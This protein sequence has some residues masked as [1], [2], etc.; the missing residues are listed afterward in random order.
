MAASTFERY[1][2]EITPAM[3][4]T[5]GYGNVMQVPR[6]QKVVVNIGVGEASQDSKLIDGA[7]ADL[8]AITG[9]QPAPRKAKK[10]ISNFKI[11]EGMVVGCCVTL[12]RRRMYDFMDRLINFA[13]PQVRDFRGLSTRSFDGRGNFNMGVKEQIIFPEMDYDKIDR[14]RGM[15]ITMVT[16]ADT[17]D[18]AIELLRLF[19]VPFSSQMEQVDG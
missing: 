18:E 4:E 10:A 9:Q 5:F 12:R 15:N 6:L 19:G 1:T 8:K 2:T 16:S 17:D 11:R 13:L 3:I 14:V 7:F